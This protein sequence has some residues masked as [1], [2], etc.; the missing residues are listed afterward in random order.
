[1]NPTLYPEP[2]VLIAS[3][4][5]PNMTRTERRDAMARLRRNAL[6]AGFAVIP[7][8]G[9]WQGAPE[10]SYVIV[11]RNRGG[12]QSFADRVLREFRQDAVL[13]VDSFRHAALFFRDGS[14]EPMGRLTATSERPQADGYT[15]VP[16]LRTYYVARK[17]A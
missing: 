8:K 5:R 17:G 12:L 11:D 15:Y 1:M 10:P 4:C 16:R 9:Y 14:T 3:A 2:A 13:Y 6:Q 7:A